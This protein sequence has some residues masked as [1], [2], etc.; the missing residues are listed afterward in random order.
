MYVEESEGNHFKNLLKTWTNA[1]ISKMYL[2]VK[3]DQA[4]FRFVVCDT[5]G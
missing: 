5:I 2:L 1:F 3:Y 4:S